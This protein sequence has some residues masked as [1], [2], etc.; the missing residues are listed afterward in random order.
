MIKIEFLLENHLLQT[1]I[2]IVNWYVGSVFVNC[3]S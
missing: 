1:D 2:L 3:F